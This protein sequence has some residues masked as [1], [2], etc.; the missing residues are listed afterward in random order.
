MIYYNEAFKQLPGG[1]FIDL[2][3]PELY[4]AVSVRDFLEGRSDVK[5]TRKFLGPVVVYYNLAGIY[6]HNVNYRRDED[7]SLK[8]YHLTGN[9]E[10]K[11]HCFHSNRLADYKP[12]VRN[13]LDPDTLKFG[14][15]RLG[16][17]ELLYKPSTD[18][19][20]L[21]GVEMGPFVGNTEV[22]KIPN[23]NF[24]YA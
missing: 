20:F 8:L 1:P 23:G 21:I 3:V 12:R 4:E 17:V 13:E 19:L 14:E 2:F 9:V 5:P 10:V 6:L 7:D 11:L 15:G 16:K 24:A 22:E 18:E